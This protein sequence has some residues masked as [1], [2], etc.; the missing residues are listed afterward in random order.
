MGNNVSWMLELNVQPG[1][2]KDF[3]ALMEEMIGGTRAN[4]PGTLAFEWSLSADG[5]T[6]HIFERYSDSAAVM[7]HAGN[8]GAKYAGRFLE[9]LKPVRMVVYGAPSN[10]VKNG[11]AAFNPVFMQPAGGF[12]R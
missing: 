6:C 8:F 4:E 9:I 11:L 10:E 12:S 2:E 1:R 3:K 7:V 5:A